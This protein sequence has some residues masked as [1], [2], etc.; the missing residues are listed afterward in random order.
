MSAV[1]HCLYCFDIIIAELQGQ[2]PPSAPLPRVEG[3]PEQCPLFVTWKTIHRHKGHHSSST[4]RLR[5]CIGT[6]APQ[7]LYHGLQQYAKQAAFKD[8]RFKP[9]TSREVPNLKCYVSL[10]TNFEDADHVWDWQPGKHGIWIEF[11]DPETGRR[12]HGTYLPEVCAENRW[13]REECLHSLYRKTGYRGPI[14]KSLM[15]KTSLERYQ[16]TKAECSYEEYL[17]QRQDD[18]A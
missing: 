12:R 9:I 7:P 5:G 4:E 16:S 17:S 3:E 6:F 8:S 1:E 15:S 13:S 2:T 18:S 14:N 10:L 11:P